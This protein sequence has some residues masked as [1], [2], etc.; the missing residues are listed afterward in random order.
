MLDRDI[1]HD[2]LNSLSK[3]LSR[4]AKDD[5]EEVIREIE[6]HI[7][8][9]LEDSGDEANVQTVLDG[10]G[11]PRELATSYVDHILE[12]SPPPAGFKAIQTIKRGA[13]KGLYFSTML[14][15]YGWSLVFICAAL[16]KL[17]WPQDIVVWAADHGNSIIIGLQTELPDGGTDII[18]WW[19]IPI[20]LI[21]GV[22]AG[23]LTNRI[24]SILKGKL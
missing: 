19:F 8:D 17:V 3:F 12:G 11:S 24:L 18:G 6:S 5:A 16:Y 10:F 1:I 20:T 22:C 23:Y 21:F 13:S 15:G 4:L 7:Y 2:Y 14:F 9:A